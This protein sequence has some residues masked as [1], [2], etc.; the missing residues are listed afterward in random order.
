MFGSHGIGVTLCSAQH[1]SRSIPSRHV[2]LRQTSVVRLGSSE[3]NRGL[4][5]G[6]RTEKERAYNKNF[7]GLRI[8]SQNE[9]TGRMYG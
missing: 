4:A 5:H 9:G 6:L 7:D 8:T 3:A 1:Q 2:T